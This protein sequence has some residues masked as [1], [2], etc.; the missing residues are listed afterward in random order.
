MQKHS[1]MRN[2]DAPG[3]RIASSL[4]QIR[5]SPMQPYSKRASAPRDLSC[6]DIISAIRLANFLVS[7]RHAV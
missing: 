5:L 7:R 1:H 4:L 2:V 3:S 6:P